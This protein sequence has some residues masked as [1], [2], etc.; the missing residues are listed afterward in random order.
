[1]V[2]SGLTLYP[3]VRYDRRAYSLTS[4]SMSSLGHLKS[5]SRGPLGSQYRSASQPGQTIN[6]HPPIFSMPSPHVGHRLTT[7]RLRSQTSSRS[8]LGR[9]R[10]VSRRTDGRTDDYPGFSKRRSE[11]G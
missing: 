10:K 11:W 8:S 2:A 4:P 1:M 9:T 7:P 3:L 5:S 6:S